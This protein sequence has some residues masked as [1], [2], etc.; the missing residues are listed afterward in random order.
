[1]KRACL[2]DPNFRFSHP[3]SD[4]TPSEQQHD[5]LAGERWTLEHAQRMAGHESPRTF[6]DDQPEPEPMSRLRQ[7]IRDNDRFSRTGH[8]KQDAMLRSVSELH[9]SVMVPESAKT[10]KPSIRREARR[11]IYP[12]CRTAGPEYY[13][14]RPLA[15]SYLS[16]QAGKEP[17]ELIILSCLNTGW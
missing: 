17:G 14:T 13:F 16:S 1:M 8:S 5:D 4:V 11:G 6:F 15:S 7:K 10:R 9:G 3:R 2:F 12:S